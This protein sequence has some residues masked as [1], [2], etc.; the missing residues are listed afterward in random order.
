MKNLPKCIGIYHDREQMLQEK[1]RF[2]L[3][4]RCYDTGRVFLQF[5]SLPISS[6]S[7]KLSMKSISSCVSSRIIAKIPIYLSIQVSELFYLYW[8]LPW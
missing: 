3:P 2:F 6:I 8:I 5:S 4:F 1:G 7:M